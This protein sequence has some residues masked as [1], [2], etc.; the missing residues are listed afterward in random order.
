VVRLNADG[1]RDESFTPALADY[2]TQPRR[3]LSLVPVSDGKIVVGGEFYSV[4]GTNRTGIARLHANGILDTSFNTGAGPNGPVRFVTLQSDGSVLIGGWFTTFDG[5]NCSSLARLNANGTLNTSFNP[6]FG[7]RH[8]RNCG[9]DVC[10]TVS[11]P[12]TATMQPD[13][14]VLVGFWRE[15]WQCD[16][17]DGGCSL[18][19]SYSITRLNADGTS[20]ASFAFINHLNNVALLGLADSIALQPD[21]KIV[22]GSSAYNTVQIARINANGSWDNSF[23]AGVG[24]GGVDAVA[25]QPDG[26]VLIGGDFTTVNGVV[27]PYVARLHGAEVAPSLSITRTMEAMT[28]AWALSAGYV[29]DQSPTTTGIWSQVA[30]PY[31]TNANVISVSKPVTTGNKFYRLR[32]L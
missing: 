1:S 3:F 23:S 28:I 20:D 24:P 2:S 32:K 26:K 17:F 22:V 15:N 19:Y 30:F 14:K 8:Y 7:V 27:R 18:S 29:L 25:L 16:A 5:T 21:G 13:G 10:Y 4:N 12:A 11:F 6:D 31:A 9:G